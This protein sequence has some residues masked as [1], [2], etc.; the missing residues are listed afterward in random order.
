MLSVIIP[1]R[2]ELYLTNTV[3]DLLLKAKG[4]I[5]IIV[6]LDGYW[7]NPI[8]VND[9]RV[10]IV[11]RGESRGMRN[12][13]NSGVAIARGEYIM[14]CDAHCM[15]DEDFDLKLI[16]DCEKNWVVVPRRKRLDVEYWCSLD[17]GKP[18][19][20]YMYLSRELHGVNW[21]ELNRDESRKSVKIDDLMSSQGSCWFMHKD[22]FYEL[23]LLDEEHYGS[24]WNEFQEIGLKCWLSGGRVVIN[25]N[26]WYAH[27]HKQTRGYSLQE[28]STNYVQ[29]WMKM[30]EAWDKQTIPIEKLI[31]KFSPVPGWEL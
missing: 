30:G 15:F 23:E 9:K 1:S 3:S 4:D 22:Y 25:K 10:I 7:A 19:V 11:H 28:Q 21:D 24:F 31:E 20:D 12:G 17:V 6:I 13:I 29:K 2:N 5:E 27:L 8:P 26:T 16:A 18:D 14:K